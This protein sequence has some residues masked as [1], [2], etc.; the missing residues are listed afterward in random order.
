MM[1]YPGFHSTAGAAS[2]HSGLT[3]CTAAHSAEEGHQTVTITE[4]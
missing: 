1:Y 2:V 3:D 4:F